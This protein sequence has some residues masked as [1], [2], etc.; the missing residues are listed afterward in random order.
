[1]AGKSMKHESQVKL[2]KVVS[3][4]QARSQCRYILPVL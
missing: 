3:K 1:M 4:Q 2:D